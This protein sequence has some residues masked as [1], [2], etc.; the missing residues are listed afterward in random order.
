MMYSRKELIKFAASM[1]RELG[2]GTLADSVDVFAGNCP[3]LRKDDGYRWQL[4]EYDP[5]LVKT[6]LAKHMGRKPTKKDVEFA[7]GFI[8]SCAD[9]MSVEDDGMFWSD[10]VEA[11]EYERKQG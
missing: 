10:L 7:M 3:S 4:D 8:E 5:A 1:I 11:L 6:A 9:N 2:D